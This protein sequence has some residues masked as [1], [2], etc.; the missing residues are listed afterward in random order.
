M[1]RDKKNT[2][3]REASKIVPTVQNVENITIHLP[4]LGAGTNSKNQELRTG[5][6]PRPIPTKNLRA[7][8]DA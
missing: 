6:P 3:A 5:P 2:H 4:L 8:N 7:I 1:S